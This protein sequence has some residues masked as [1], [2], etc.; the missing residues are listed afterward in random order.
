MTPIRIAGHTHV[1]GVPK[2]WKPER[3]G[4]CTGLAVRKIENVWQSAWE[5]TPGELDRLA[6]GAKIVL[7]IV[8][9]QP[10][11]MLTV[12]EAEIDDVV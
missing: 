6:A 1:L 5:P 7:S 2:E 9:G 12:E 10:P 8:G 11:V 3:D 4:V